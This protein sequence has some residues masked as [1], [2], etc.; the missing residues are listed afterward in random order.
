MIVRPHLSSVPYFEKSK[1]RYV[2][3]RENQYRV[4]IHADVVKVKRLNAPPPP[5]GIHKRNVVTGFSKRSRKRMIELFA[6]IV[7][8]PDLFCT[9]TWSD[10]VATLDPDK[11]KRHFEAFRRRLEY[12]YADLKAVWRIEVETRKSGE[13][14]GEPLAHYHLLIWLP[15]G[16]PELKKSL[17]NGNGNLW[18]EWWHDVTQSKHEWH[19]K[20]YGLQLEE[21]KSRRHC[22]HYVSKYVAKESTEQHA[23][24]R[25]W[26]RVGQLDTLPVFEMDVTQEQ[27]IQLKRLIASYVKKRKKSIGKRIARGNVNKGL[28]GFGLGAWGERKTGL[29]NSTIVTMIFHAIELSRTKA[30]KDENSKIHRDRAHKKRMAVQ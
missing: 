18:R 13:R 23:I 21:I 20:R 9:L 30:S 12:H 14:K 25:R 27:Y 22:Y 24:G 7:D 26:G 8:V 5:H 11:F 2:D 17:L 19:K 16:N 6:M 29:E 1:S 3:R 10:D 28:T 15:K 4:S